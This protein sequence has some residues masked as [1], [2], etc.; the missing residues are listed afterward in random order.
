MRAEVAVDLLVRPAREI[1]AGPIVTLLNPIIR[2]GNLTVMDEELTL[3]GQ[4][5]FLGDFPAAGVLRVA[6]CRST[7]TIVG[8]QEVLYAARTV[9]AFRHVGEVGTFVSL[10]HA[11]RG[12]GR[13]LAAE[14]FPEARRRGFTKLMATIRADNPNALAFYTALGFRTVGVAE[15]HARVRGRYVDEILA[16]RW[17]GD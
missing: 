16:E 5:A 13:A 14:T 12:I 7:R 15:R 8:I 3:E 17:I 4:I 10:A 2:A 1:D 11:R 9:P 6:E